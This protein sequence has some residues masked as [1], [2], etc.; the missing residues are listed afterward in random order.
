MKKIQ[1]SR[2]GGPEELRLDEVDTPVPGKGQ[3]LVR[4]KAASINPMDWKIRRGEMKPLSGLKFPR[5]LGHDFSGVIE[6][7]GQGVGEYQRGDEVLGL[8]SIPRAGALAASVVADAKNVWRKPPGVSFED[9]AALILVGVTA[10]TAL[11]EKAELQ[12]GQSVF[13]NGC[14]GS[15]GRSAVQLAIS[16]GAHV[17]GSCS[18]NGLG[19]ARALGV[20]EAVDYESLDPHS[21]EHRF[22]VVFDTVGTLSLTMCDVMLRPDGVSLHIVPNFSKWIGSL[23][24]RRHHLVFGNPTPSSLNGI[25]EAAEKGALVAKIGLVVPLSKAIPAIVA[26]ETTGTPKGKLVI[27]PD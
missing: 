4:V 12:A 14:L 27:V 26:L 1:Y 17:V 16:R 19:E 24:S 18:R 2:Y 9:A 23:F 6:A 8:T 20:R 13:V 3:V 22:D 10:W 11:V 7:V 21:F 25:A 5:G 15:V